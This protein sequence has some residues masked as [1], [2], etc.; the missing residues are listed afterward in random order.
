MSAPRWQHAQ[1]VR[2]G[3][4]VT[5]ARAGRLVTLPTVRL[6]RPGTAPSR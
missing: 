6:S 4:M 3:R 5:S 2:A 1:V